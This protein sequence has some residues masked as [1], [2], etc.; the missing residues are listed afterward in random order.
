MRLLLTRHNDP[1]PPSLQVSWS[2]PM[3]K[4]NWSPNKIFQLVKN[5]TNVFNSF[6]P[7]H[8]E[9]V[10]LPA[11]SP[12][13][14]RQTWMGHQSTTERLSRHCYPLQWRDQTCWHHPLSDH[15]LRCLEVWWIEIVQ[16]RKN[17]QWISHGRARIIGKYREITNLWTNQ[18]WHIPMGGKD[19]AWWRMTG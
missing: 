11:P 15:S 1:A 8:K 4:P 18:Y 16:R 5:T 17:S 10:V 12:W 6:W 7:V 2:S 19:G 14:G 3:K 9:A 13:T